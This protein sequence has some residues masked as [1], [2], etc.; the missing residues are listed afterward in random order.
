MSSR[1]TRI[2]RRLLSGA[3]FAAWMLLYLAGC[4]GLQPDPAYNRNRPGKRS[5]PA[6]A[7]TQPRKESEPQQASPD[8]RPSTTQPGGTYSRSSRPN[9]PYTKD[10]LTREIDA[11]WGS[12]YRW[13][14]NTRGGVDCSGYTVALMKNVYGVTLPRTSSQQFRQGSSVSRSHLRRGDLVFFNTNGRGVSHVGVYLG[15]GKFTHA[16]NSDG[17]TIDDLDSPY[18]RKRYMGARRVVQ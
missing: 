1:G 4:A 6:P 16:S 17:V 13:G 8:A 11:W 12:P 14:G 15:G 3:A 7:Q 10:K 18:Y 9:D 5:E 2:R